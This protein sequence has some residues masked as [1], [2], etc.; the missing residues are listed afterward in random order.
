M[1]RT[2]FGQLP[3]H[4]S[5]G[6]L[7]LQF[8]DGVQ[9]LGPCLVARILFEIGALDVLLLFRVALRERN[10]QR[11]LLA[12]SQ[13]GPVLFIQRGLPLLLLGQQLLLVPLIFLPHRLELGPNGIPSRILFGSAEFQDRVVGA[14]PS[15][16]VLEVT[17]QF[18]DVV[19]KGEEPVELPLGH[20]VVLVVVAAGAA[21]GQTQ[22]DDPGGVHPVD[23]GF[24]PVLLEV[25][26]PFQIQLGV[27][28]KPAG[29]DLVLGG[30]G[31]QVPGDLLDH[32]LVVG[33]IPVQGLDHPVPIF[34]DLAGQVVVVS[35]GV[36]V[37]GQVEPVASPAL[38]VVGGTQKIVDEA[39]V[40]VR[41]RIFQKRLH[42]P[43]LG[44]QS[45]QVQIGP[46]D[47]GRLLGFRG[48]LQ[49]LPV[50]TGEDE[51]VDGIAHPGG[52]GNRRLRGTPDRLEGPVPGRVARVLLPVRSRV[53]PGESHPDPADQ[54]RDLMIGQRLLRGH[55]QLPL[56]ADRMNEAALLGQTRGDG[57]TPIAPSED[58]F[59]AVRRKPAGGQLFVVATGALVP[60][61]RPDPVFEELD[62]V[63]RES[64]GARRRKQM[65][66]TA[67]A[68]DRDCRDQANHG[69]SVPL[70]HHGVP[71]RQGQLPRKNQAPRFH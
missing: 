41:A 69:A 70:F 60:E 54:R 59:P 47:Q 21:Q 26:A 38:A 62:L 18:V 14:A 66:M 51:T 28:V 44:Q 43:G 24:D 20:G 68:E 65:E 10:H 56:A 32:E 16:F 33:Q 52:I 22:E 37:A 29:H 12:R 2:G 1:G 3:H 9:G 4:Q 27:A 34:P 17:A 13:L 6:D 50:K 61:D 40:G 53:G 15:G 55:F 42:L 31:D 48:G 5:A 39:L 19:E 30:V 8:F 35:V 25:D 67:Y 57:F 23:H 45:D 11:R 58:R 64:C 7:R 36:G 71:S 46:A 63:R 49:A